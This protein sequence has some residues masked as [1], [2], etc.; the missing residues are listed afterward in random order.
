[1]VWRLWI[2]CIILSVLILGI[3]SIKCKV[4]L[5]TGLL[6]GFF[7]GIATGFFVNGFQKYVVDLPFRVMLGVEIFFIVLLTV[8]VILYMF[9]RD[10]DR[11]ISRR[12]NVILSPADGK[13]RYVQSLEN[14]K[15]PFS[16]KRKN[17]FQL[18]ELTQSDLLRDGAFLI[19]IEMSIID[20][21]V[22]RAPVSGK[23]VLQKYTK[24]KFLSLRQ[25]ESLFE[26]ERLTTIIDTGFFK[27]G[28]VQIASRLVRRIVSYFNQGDWVDI[29]QR[30]GMIR[31]GSQVD[32]VIPRLKNLRINSKPGDEIKA[33]ISVVAEYTR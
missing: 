8:C 1:M 3:I 32:L 29:G 18:N 7:I 2:S 17:L 11:I 28:V 20:V 13:V 14:G 4:K 27:L 5:Y 19:G 24:G 33:G 12:D 30:I 22:N 16:Q 10:P 6:T 25:I 31:F 15:I 9:F 21:H 23:I 26:N